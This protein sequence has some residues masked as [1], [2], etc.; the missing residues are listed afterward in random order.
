MTKTLPGWAR[1]P[2]PQSPL[3]AARAR[4][5]WAAQPAPARSLVPQRAPQNAKQSTTNLSDVLWDVQK[6][7]D[8]S[9]VGTF[10]VCADDF[11]HAAPPE[12]TVTVGASSPH[13]MV[14]RGAAGAA[15]ATPVCSPRAPI[16][17]PRARARARARSRTEGS[18]LPALVVARAR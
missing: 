16:A 17:R 4:A 14:L 13:E 11:Y 6:H 8:D 7:L 2:A 18:S 9:P 3:V 12:L 15:A 5:L 10:I 1:R